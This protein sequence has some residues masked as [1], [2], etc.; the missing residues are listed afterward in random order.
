[1]RQ[2][3]RPLS[4][5]LGMTASSFR[6]SAGISQA[7]FE[8]AMRKMLLGINAYQS[9]PYN[10]KRKK[11]N[12]VLRLGE[13]TIRAPEKKVRRDGGPVL[14]LVPSMV[15]KAYIM[16]LM[17][18][19]SMLRWLRKRGIQ[20]CLLDWGD[21]LRD[22]DLKTI[23]AAI[24]KKLM[25]AAKFLARQAGGPIHALG[26]CMGGTLLAGAA[27]LEAKTFKSLIFLAAPWDFHAGSNALQKR[28]KFWA[29]SA[30]PQMREKGYLPVDWMQTV[31]A[32]LD[33]KATAAKFSRFAALDQG[34][35]ESRIFVAVEDWLNDG[36][37]LPAEIAREPIEEWF[38]ENRAARGKWKIGAKTVNTRDI[39]APALVIASQ[40][41]RLVEYETAAALAKK[42]KDAKII[43]PGCGHIGMM[44]G[45]EAVEK[46]W[47]P[48]AE[49]VKEKG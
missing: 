47:K 16:D 7:E 10:A 5:H 49:W 29:P 1:M 44:A 13:V 32:S 27:S 23:G 43:N 9:H 4:A 17:P 3:P 37:D 48:I 36:T 38:L 6:E 20:A 19:R 31:F 18:Q 35:E 40:R 25:P 24:Q 15:N 26:Y 2:G 21:P 39:K 22:K 11:L 45:R 14:L 28:V 46:V 41:D 12:T 8:S 33:P 42:I 34:S 30:M